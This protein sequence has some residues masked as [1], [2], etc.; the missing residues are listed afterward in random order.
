MCSHAG[1]DGA[2]DVGLVAVGGA[3]GDTQL[4]EPWKIVVVYE[5]EDVLVLNKP[6]G[7]GF[8]TEVLVPSLINQPAP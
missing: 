7:L 3:P 1:V 8:H 2:V 4:A 6:S 5:D